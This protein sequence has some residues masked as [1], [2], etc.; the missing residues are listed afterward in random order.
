MGDSAHYQLEVAHDLLRLV[1]DW[2]WL[3]AERQEF[4]AECA[5]FA[6]LGRLLL[7]IRTRIEDAGRTIE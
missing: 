7:E 2:T 3:R 1:E 6:G 4:P 5:V